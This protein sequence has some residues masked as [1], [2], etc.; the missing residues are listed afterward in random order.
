M[1]FMTSVWACFSVFTGYNLERR[2]PFLDNISPKLK[3]KLRNLWSFCGGIVQLGNY[4][5]SMH[6][7]KIYRKSY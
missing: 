1:I 7:D 5:S 2:H 4:R 6:L 3:K